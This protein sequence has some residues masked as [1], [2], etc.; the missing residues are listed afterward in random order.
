M[1]KQFEGILE[2][3]TERGVIYFHQTDK[4]LIDE[5][6]TITLLRI[7]QLPKP[8]PE[9]VISIDITYMKSVSYEV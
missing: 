2:I 9:K 6:Q 3:D 5:M 8:I 7:C 1:N 4:K